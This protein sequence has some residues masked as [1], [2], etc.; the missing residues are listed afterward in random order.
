MTYDP[1][2]W[3]EGAAPG[4]SAG[5]LNRIEKG[6][7]DAHL[8]PII[9]ELDASAHSDQYPDGKSYMVVFSSASGWPENLGSVYT[10]VGGRGSGQR[11]WQM[12]FGKTSSRVYIRTRNNSDTDWEDWNEVAFGNRVAFW[13]VDG[14]YEQSSGVTLSTS[15][16]TMA[17]VNLSIPSYWSSWKCE[18]YA[19]FAAANTNANET[20]IRNFQVLLNIDNQNSQVQLFHVPGGGYY[21]SSS[22]GARRTG[23]TTTGTRQVTLRAR[24]QS[25]SGGELWYRYLYA[26]A[27]RTG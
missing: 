9:P 8:G 10:F 16:S 14:S 22:I 2:T 19:T 4:I 18:A 15:Y 11:I 12:F 5:E 21:Q 6:I 24:L 17:T 26:R 25:G 3:N 13:E 7:V 20:A 27:V 23:M 1:T